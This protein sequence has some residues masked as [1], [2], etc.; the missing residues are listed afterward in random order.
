MTYIAHHVTSIGWPTFTTRDSDQ[1][2]YITHYVTL[3]RWPT[4]HILWHWSDDLHCTSRDK[5]V[6]YIHTTWPSVTRLLHHEWLQMSSDDEGGTSER[7]SVLCSPTPG[8]RRHGQRRR[9]PGETCG[10]TSL[11]PLPHRERGSRRTCVP[12]W[13][14]SVT[15][16]TCVRVSK[17]W[18][19]ESWGMSE[20]V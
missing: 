17:E 9:T 15:P 6:T 1:V 12:P 10:E 8:T 14:W 3:I 20:W 5:E 2:T 16:G 7:R 18:R 4:M 13:T 19:G 11:H